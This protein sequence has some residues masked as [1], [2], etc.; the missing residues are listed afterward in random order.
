VKLC[1]IQVS[2]SSPSS[3]GGGTGEEIFSSVELQLRFPLVLLQA[4]VVGLRAVVA[5]GLSSVFALFPLV[6]LQAKVV[7]LA[8]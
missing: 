6:L 4:K 5:L 1:K 7:G 2:I 3:E 8:S